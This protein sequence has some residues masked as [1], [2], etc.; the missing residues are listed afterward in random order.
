MIIKVQSSNP[1]ICL[2]NPPKTL[3]CPASPPVELVYDDGEKYE[4]TDHHQNPDSKSNSKFNG[5]TVRL[6]KE[7]SNG[8]YSNAESYLFI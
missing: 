3:V 6:Y 5:H 8:T 4:H 2:Q 1:S 7:M